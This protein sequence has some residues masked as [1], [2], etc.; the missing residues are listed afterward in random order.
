MRPATAETFMDKV[1][2]EPN[3]GCWL[4]GGH[5]NDKG[6]GMVR[7]RGKTRT[8]H[9]VSFELANGPIPDGAHV[10]HRCDVRWCVNPGHL[11]LGT[12]AQNM[13]DKVARGC[14]GGLRGEQNPG[15][16]LTPADVDIVVA[17]R[18]AGEGPTSIARRL[19]VTRQTI[20]NITSGRTWA[21]KRCGGMRQAPLFVAGVGT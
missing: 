7:W 1:H 21:A 11:Y 9:R 15:A 13:A 10:L 19:G 4:F 12:H 2:H 14:S 5:L 6:Y 20:T 18:A 3:T 16:K 17:A 8:A